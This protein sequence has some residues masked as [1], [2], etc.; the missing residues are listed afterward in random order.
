MYAIDVLHYLVSY[1]MHAQ[2]VKYTDIQISLHH[3][4][5]FPPPDM[6]HAQLSSQ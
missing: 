4:Y 3:K 5:H 6:H 2:G 1:I